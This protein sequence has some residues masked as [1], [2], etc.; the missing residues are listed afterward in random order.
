M[1][2]REIRRWIARAPSDV[3][4]AICAQTLTFCELGAK[5]AL[6]PACGAEPRIGASATCR[7]RLGACRLQVTSLEPGRLLAIE[8][9]DSGHLVHMR[10]TLEP[11]CNGTLV[12]CHSETEGAFPGATRSAIAPVFRALSQV[13]SDVKASLEQA[14][15][16]ANYESASY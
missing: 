11:W 5:C 1:A 4:A 13:V 15:P 16:R 9:S 8:V 7:S 10:F 12:S 3:F 14:R 6:Q 2:Q